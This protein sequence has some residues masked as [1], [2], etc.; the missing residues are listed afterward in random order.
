LD[1]FDKLVQEKLAKQ[2]GYGQLNS[3]R[4]TPTPKHVHGE[5]PNR[6]NNASSLNMIGH[7]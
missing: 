1:F 4:I 5:V 3:A 7:L 6:N 2:G